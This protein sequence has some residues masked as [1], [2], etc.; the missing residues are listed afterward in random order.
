MQ[1]ACLK[2]LSRFGGIKAFRA[3]ASGEFSGAEPTFAL[4]ERGGESELALI[5][6][7]A[8]GGPLLL[9]ERRELP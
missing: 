5:N 4:L 7:L 1:G 2:S 6:R 3:E 8:E 9:G